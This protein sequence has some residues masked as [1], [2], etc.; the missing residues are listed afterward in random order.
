[1]AGI[2]GAFDLPTESC[3]EK[4]QKLLC[5]QFSPHAIQYLPEFGAANRKWMRRECCPS[6][7]QSPI[8][9][10]GHSLESP[11]R[12]DYAF[13]KKYLTLRKMEKYVREPV[14]T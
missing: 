13:P 11:N 3:L 1:M 5:G 2:N 10:S 7:H 4:V 8:K 6:G 14:Q 12:R 9:I